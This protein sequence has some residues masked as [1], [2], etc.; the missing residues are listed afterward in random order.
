[1]KVTALIS[2]D[3]V[4][5]VKQLTNGK[6]ITDSLTIAL[7]EWVSMKEIETLN[8]SIKEDPVEFLDDFTAENV[9]KLSRQ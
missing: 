8:Y 4:N 7:N 5:K 1:M 6:N 3:L 2:D 9:R